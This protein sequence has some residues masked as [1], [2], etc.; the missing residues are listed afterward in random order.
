[1]ALTWSEKVKECTVSGGMND[2]VLNVQLRSDV[3]SDPSGLCLA[4]GRLWYQKYGCAGAVK[5]RA[6]MALVR[7][8]LHPLHGTGDVTVGKVVKKMNTPPVSKGSA[9]V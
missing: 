4:V 1:M 8:T 7:L 9:P 6:P 3:V 5:F 2:A